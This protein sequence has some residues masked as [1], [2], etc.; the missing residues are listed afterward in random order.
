M[1][2]P[3]SAINRFELGTTFAE[4]DL[5][6]NQKGFIGTQ[7][8]RPRVVGKN[9]ADVGKIPLKQLLQSASTRRSPGGAFA[10]DTFEFDK[11]PYSVGFYGKEEPLADENVAMYGDIID[12]EQ[13]SADRAE[14]A[15]LNEYERDVAAAVYNTATWTG[16]ALTTA[17]VNEWDDF[18]NATPIADVNNAIEKVAEGSG[19]EANALVLNR[20]ELRNLLQCDEIVDRIK[21][22]QTPTP[23]MIKNALADLFDLKYILVAGGFKNTANAGQ[24]AAIERIWSSE[25]AMVCRV[26]E[27]DD[28]REACIGRTFIWSGDGPGAPGDGGALA[29]AMKEYREEKVNSVVFQ[30]SNNRDIVIMYAQA[31][32]LLSNVTT[33]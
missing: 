12:A 29:V 26:A 2:T 15:V 24:D 13:V 23:A 22:T 16:V 17:I 4:F 21:Y 31:G 5:K 25:Y 14:D 18:A 32:H 20:K 7:V 27:S 3:S 30:A 28:P 1:A 19:L 11:F 6:M 8:L 10:R 33:I 9:A